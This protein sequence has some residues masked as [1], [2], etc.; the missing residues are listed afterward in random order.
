MIGVDNRAYKLTAFCIG[1]ALAG[2]AGGFLAYY[3][4]S[5]SPDSFGF[6]TSISVLCMVVSVECNPSRAAS[7]PPRC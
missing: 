4:R 1:T 6:S 2:L 7:L 5:V 3:L